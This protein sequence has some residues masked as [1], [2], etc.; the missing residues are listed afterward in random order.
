VYFFVLERATNADQSYRYRNRRFTHVS[1][2]QS[3][4][5]LGIVWIRRLEE[6]NCTHLTSSNT[7]YLSER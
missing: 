6:R 1:G 3:G 5:K 7:N 4:L 2:L